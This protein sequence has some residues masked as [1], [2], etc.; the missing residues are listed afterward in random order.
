MAPYAG[1]LSCPQQ[2]WLRDKVFNAQIEASQQEPCELEAP[3]DQ[4]AQRDD[5]S[6]RRIPN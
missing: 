3:L 2:K 1:I 4:A 6:W 5:Y